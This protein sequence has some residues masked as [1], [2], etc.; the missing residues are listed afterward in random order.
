MAICHGK[1]LRGLNYN[2][3][4]FE[5]YLRQLIAYIGT[6]EGNLGSL[7]A[8]SATAPHVYRPPYK[9]NKI[10]FQPRLAPI[11]YSPL[12]VL[13]LKPKITQVEVTAA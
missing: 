13:M 8:I 2:Q 5:V 10:P 4:S 11:L 12:S 3:Y 9:P 6:Y 1:S 7:D